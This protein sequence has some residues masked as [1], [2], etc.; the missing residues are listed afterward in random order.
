[1]ATILLVLCILLSTTLSGLAYVMSDN[2]TGKLPSLGWNSWNTFNCDVNEDHFLTA[3][4]ELVNRGLK[5]AGYEYVNSKKVSHDLYAIQLI[6][7]VDDCWMMKDGRD[8]D[9]HLIPNVTRFPDGIKSLA[10]KVH[11]MGLKLGIYSCKELVS[12]L[13][14]LLTRVGAGSRTCAGY[15]ASLEH[16]DMDASDF[17]SWGIDCA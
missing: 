2:V 14:L 15:P 5:D 11:D 6:V 9:G 16:E 3:A 10:D 4:E 12:Q 13:S 17:A 8:D 1:M 7:T